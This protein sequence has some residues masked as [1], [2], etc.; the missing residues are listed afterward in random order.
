MEESNCMLCLNYIEG[1]C[2]GY[3]H[4]YCP[5]YRIEKEGN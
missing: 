2:P 5:N 4:D 1:K 3:N